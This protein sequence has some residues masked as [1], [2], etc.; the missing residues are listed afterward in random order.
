MSQYF[1]PYK[2][3][4]GDIKVE[5]DLSD[6][7][8]KADL[9]NVTHVDAS[10]F[11]SKTNL[12]A[13]KTEV[14]KINTDKSKT[15]PDDLAKLSN[16]V[17]ND[18]VKSTFNTKITELEDKITTA[19]NKIADYST[20]I[21][22]IKNDYVTNTALD[23]KLN[24]LKSQHIADEVKKIDDKTK[25]NAS[26][27]LGFESRLKQKEDI[28]NEGQRENSF[29]RG[30]YYYL[31]KSYLVYKCRAY[32]FKKDNN[33]KLTTCKSTGIDNLSVNSDLKAIPDATSLLPSLD[34]YCRMNVNFS[35]N[36]FVQNKVLHLNNNNVVNIY[37]I[38]M[39]NPIIFSRNTD[40]T[41]HNTLCGAIKITENIDSSKSKYERYGIRF[42]E[43]GSFTSGN[44]TNG[45]N[46]LI[47]GAD[48]SFSTHPTNKVNNIYVLG[49]DFVQGINGTTLY[50]EKIYKTNF[51]E[52]NKKLVSSLHYNFSNSYLFVNGTQELRFKTKSDQILK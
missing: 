18:L 40:Y 31:Q 48:M 45:R 30:F 37:I 17:K 24:D 12:A 41:I 39:L 43:G 47:S 26:D 35:G 16:V 4:R 44:I 19:D 25:K 49:K 28:V 5:L 23:S 29:T 7:A 46:V 34:K 14:D 3:F 52:A 2:N 15:V 6:Y 32:S 42:D 8:T 11:G 22:S 27:T 33:D 21:T 20:E 36:Y 10:S 50:A 1:P 38:Y 13:L 51:T 9:K